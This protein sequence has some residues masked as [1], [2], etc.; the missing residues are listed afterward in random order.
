VRSAPTRSSAGAP[1]RV[2]SSRYT[3]SSRSMGSRPAGRPSFSGRSTFA[4]RSGGF[5]GRSR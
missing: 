5:G 1:T 4:G 2:G 3:P